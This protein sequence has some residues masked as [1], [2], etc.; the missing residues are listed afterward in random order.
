MLVL[1]YDDKL[2][3]MYLYMVFMC[4]R[5]YPHSIIIIDF[6]FTIL[7]TLNTV[8]LGLPLY[9]HTLKRRTLM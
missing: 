3:H 5:Y 2:W 9:L 4:K 6:T 8:M 1:Y 7:N